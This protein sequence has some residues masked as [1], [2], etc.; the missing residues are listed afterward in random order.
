[1]VIAAALEGARAQE[2]APLPADAAQPGASTA[3]DAGQPAEASE[4]IVVVGR[5]PQ[6]PLP[7]SRVP[8][9]IHTIDAAEVRRSARS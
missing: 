2:S 3:P 5:L 8:A 9:S 4:E 1:M 6:V 7:P